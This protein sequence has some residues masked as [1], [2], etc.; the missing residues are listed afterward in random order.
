M[1]YDIILSSTAFLN[2][3]QEPNKGLR[4]KI[5]FPSKILLSSP[6]ANSH[7]SFYSVFTHPF[8]RSRKCRGHPNPSV[9]DCRCWL[10]QPTEHRIRT[11]LPP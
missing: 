9:V 10:S 2:S 1:T 8:S 6:I 5:K 7:V 3:P 11:S 4:L